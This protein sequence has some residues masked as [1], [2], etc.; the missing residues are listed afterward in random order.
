MARGRRVQRDDNVLV[1]PGGAR[2]NDAI[3]T[4]L[5]MRGGARGR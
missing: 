1:P 2:N 5:G 4:V 3:S